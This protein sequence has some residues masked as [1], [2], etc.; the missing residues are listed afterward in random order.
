M[1]LTLGWSCGT[2]GNSQRCRPP[3]PPPPPPLLSCCHW[4]SWWISRKV[5]R[6]PSEGLIQWGTSSG[7]P[8]RAFDLE[9]G[10]TFSSSLLGLV[11]LAALNSFFSRL[12]LSRSSCSRALLF[13]RSI[14]LVTA[15]CLSCSSALTFPILL[16]SG[17]SFSCLSFSCL[18]L[19]FRRV[20]PSGVISRL[21]PNL[22]SSSS[23][24]DDGRSSSSSTG[25]L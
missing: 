10:R 11:S 19:P 12:N 20:L 13:S 4:L 25:S 9:A 3:P 16:E 15:R 5:F 6:L 18:S 23:N 8:G 14:S 21:W 22:S 17:F 7:G 2:W 1:A 24:S